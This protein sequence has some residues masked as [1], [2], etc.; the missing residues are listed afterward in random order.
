MRRPLR[1][2][3]DF[4]KWTLVI[5]LVAFTLLLLAGRF[6][7]NQLSFY[8]PTIEARLQQAL[9]VPV[10]T[11]RVRGEWQGVLPLISLE[12]VQVGGD[13]PFL[14]ME[15]MD[16]EP[17]Y[18]RSFLYQ[19]LVVRQMEIENLTLSFREDAQ[20]RWALGELAGTNRA[21]T[22]LRRRLL[23]SLAE[24][25]RIES[26]NTRIELVA[27]SGRRTELNLSSLTSVKDED[28]HRYIAEAWVASEHNIINLVAETG[29]E[30]EDGSGR[31]GSAY[32]NVEGDR[33]EE[34]LRSFVDQFP[35]EA[36]QADGEFVSLQTEVW[37]DIF[38]GWVF[39]YSGTL[40]LDSLP[41]ESGPLSFES[42][43]AGSSSYGGEIRVD[44]INPIFELDTRE[45]PLFDFSINQHRGAQSNLVS[46]AT[47]EFALG[48]FYAQLAERDLLSGRLAEVLAQLNPRGTVKNLLV[49]LDLE[50]PVG[51]LNVRGNLE[52]V[53]LDAFIRAP[54]VNNLSGYFEAGARQGFV[55]IDAEN[56]A[57]FYEGVYEQP[58]YHQRMNGIVAWEVDPVKGAVEV[59]S[60]R[61]RISGPEGDIVGA[62]RVE[63]PLQRR[64]FPTDLIIEIGLANSSSGHRLALVPKTLP[65]NVRAWI[66]Q[67]VV[68]GAVPEASFVYRG[69]LGRPVGEQ[70]V[71]LNLAI[72]EGELNFAPGWP[73]LSRLNA[74]LLVNNSDVNVSASRAYIRDI[75]V[76]GAVVRVYSDRSARINISSAFRGDA[77]Q[78]LDLIRDTPV[79]RRV[80]SG[81]DEFDFGGDLLGSA[82]LDF[83][84]SGSFP[85]EELY[86]DISVDLSGNDLQLGEIGIQVDGLQ[87]T[88]EFDDA[89]L[90]AESV[91]GLLWE[92]PIELSI[93]SG[94]QVRVDLNTEISVLDI[95]DW[96]QTDWLDSM[97]GVASVQGE[98]D[99]GGASSEQQ[100]SY[101]F[102]SSLEGVTS[103]FPAPFAKRA[104]DV[105]ELE[106]SNS[107]L[108]DGSV[109]TL[110]LEELMEFSLQ[111]SEDG[112]LRQA[113]LGVNAPAPP[114]QPGILTGLVSLENPR[115]EDWTE[116][117]AGSSGN[118]SV[119]LG[120]QPNIEV[121]AQDVQMGGRSFGAMHALFNRQEELW[122]IDF[123]SVWGRG[124]YR[125]Q[126]SAGSDDVIPQLHFGSLDLLAWKVQTG[127]SENTDPRDVP[128]LNLSIDQLKYG[129]RDFGTWSFGLS[130]TEDGV[131]LVDIVATRDDIRVVSEDRATHLLWRYDGESHF[132]QMDLSLEFGDA[133]QLFELL[134]QPSPITSDS[135]SLYSFFAWSGAPAE[136]LDQPL[137]GVM[138]IR[139]AEGEFDAQVEGVGNALM[140]VVGLFNISSWARRLQFDFSDVTARG[141]SYDR[142]RGD[143]VL[144]EGV[145]TTL[146]PVDARLS[147]G[148]MRFD[149]QVDLNEDTVD[150]QLVA[151]LP[152][153]E[154]MTWVTG[155]VAG[156]PAAAGVWLIGKLFEEEV[157][158]LTSVSYRIT[159]DLEDPDV[160]TERVLESTIGGG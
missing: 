32:L 98:I 158:N 85:I 23:D 40:K 78:V 97:S 5:A 107:N 61:L 116:L 64:A 44:F 77:N 99:I 117:L 113:S 41:S 109:L 108:V 126:A 70:T 122:E 140:R 143:F 105:L 11:G 155:L 46:F 33:V 56:I 87:G 127:P 52:S 75:D 3:A 57:P 9:G 118:N 15:R 80:G 112:Q 152:L 145:L 17:D 36:A 100:T 94:E 159:G 79:R 89:G 54:S 102:Y 27:F 24:S 47:N 76:S 60:D 14:T 130:P 43:L 139:L 115:V 1:Q 63:A 4:A 157:D 95:A 28:F 101:R 150:A 31:I 34:L 135:G 45:L 22:E 156:L 25:Q 104:A 71:Q 18:L 149:G 160:R 13:Q 146:T 148:R 37:V 91:T 142:V 133:S 8:Q 53:D 138:G 124:V 121:S 10:S 154:N 153:R 137:S 93:A 136:M 65:E 96:L 42:S 50:D 39:G 92:R 83:P 69:T 134:D 29:N 58:F 73:T 144:D 35:L 59:F 119:A 82:E 114:G 62:F 84:L 106:L 123:A 55:Q 111:R 132:T 26:R 129:E 2:C 38:P 6:V 68:M 16:L 72:R 103:D 128:R 90:H 120:L 48:G 21:D 151:T 88:L 74:N 19:T 147:S 141:T 51:T 49:D 110:R 7:V 66:E 81:L 125:V 67:A 30:L 12:A 131:E 86:A 20:G